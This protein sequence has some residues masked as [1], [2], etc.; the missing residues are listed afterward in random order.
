MLDF[1]DEFFFFWLNINVLNIS[2]PIVIVVLLDLSQLSLESITKWVEFSTFYVFVPLI[3]KHRS[4]SVH[5]NIQSSL[6]LL[7]PSNLIWNAWEVSDLTECIVLFVVSFAKELFFQDLDI[8][9]HL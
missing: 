6:D 5:V 1:E 3:S 8:F 2:N 7:S 4:N 9:L